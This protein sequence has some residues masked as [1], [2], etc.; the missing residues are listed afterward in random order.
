METFNK[1][2]WSALPKFEF[3]KTPITTFTVC[4]YMNSNKITV[5]IHNS[6]QNYWE[7][8][9]TIEK[10][11]SSVWRSLNGNIFSI[12]SYYTVK[13]ILNTIKIICYVLLYFLGRCR[14]LF[15]HKIFI[16]FLTSFSYDLL[17]CIMSQAISRR[18]RL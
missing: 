18:N 5:S 4:S 1:P 7:C 11:W 6:Q 17:S 3:S 15:V 12:Y 16:H 8:F 14:H 10:H 9:F 2:H 13:K